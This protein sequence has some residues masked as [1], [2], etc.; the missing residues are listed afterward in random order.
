MEP[1]SR[2]EGCSRAHASDQVD[3]TASNKS[4]LDPASLHF[5]RHDGWNS[6]QEAIIAV[7][8]NAHNL[9]LACLISFLVQRLPCCVTFSRLPQ[10]KA[11]TRSYARYVLL[12]QCS[13]EHLGG[14]A[15]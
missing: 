2:E 12:P 1:E 7:G 4:P 11:G 13:T 3:F 6:Y 8:G 9:Q 10:G 14:L 5:R 15:S